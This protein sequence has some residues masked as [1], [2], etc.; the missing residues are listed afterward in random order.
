M[1]L[2]IE[3]PLELLLEVVYINGALNDKKMPEMIEL[4]KLFES[5]KSKIIQK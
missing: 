1:N 5:L 4:N 3:K 2:E